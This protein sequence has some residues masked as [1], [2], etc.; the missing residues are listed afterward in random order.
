MYELHI[1]A[2]LHHYSGHISKVGRKQIKHT[3]CRMMQRMIAEIMHYSS[4]HNETDYNSNYM[5][6]MIAE[7]SQL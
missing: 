6:Y 7:G 4:S 3:A 2:I 5:L 1:A